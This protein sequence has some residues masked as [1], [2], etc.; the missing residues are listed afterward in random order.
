MSVPPWEAFLSCL[1]Q[2]HLLLFIEPCKE[3]AATCAA[4]ADTTAAVVYQDSPECWDDVSDGL[5]DGTANGA[6]AG[7]RVRGPPLNPEDL[8]FC[9]R[10]STEVG[11]LAPIQS[12]CILMWHRRVRI[13][14]IHY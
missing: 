3:G 1:L 13:M 14:T 7:L 11:S 8:L 6:V 10:H 12:R 9:R 4:S 2:C 5:R